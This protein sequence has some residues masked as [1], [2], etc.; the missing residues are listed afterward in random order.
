MFLNDTAPVATAVMTRAELAL[1]L[2]AARE[3]LL[4]GQGELELGP[5]PEVLPGVDEVADWTRPASGRLE[6][7]E[8]E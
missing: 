6:L 5:V 7:E 2:R 8:G 4:P 1:L 3:R